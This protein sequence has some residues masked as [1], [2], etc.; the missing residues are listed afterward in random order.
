MALVL[1]YAP[2][3]CSGVTINALEELGLDC[4][5]RK[6]DLSSGEQKTEAYRKINPYGKVPAL[7]SDDKL[8]TENPAILLYLHSLVADSTLLPKTD[9]KY[10]AA[11]YSSDLMWMSSSVHPSVRHV[12]MPMY[13]TLN[14][15]TTDVVEKGRQS[16][17]SYFNIAEK[18]LH[19]QAWWY[20]SK[21]S[22]VDV[23]LHWCYTRA[24]RGGY[25]LSDF[26]AL[27]E[28][29]QR[30]EARP[31]FQRRKAIENR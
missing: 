1:Y 13:Y 7:I 5:Y 3:A 22:I 10:Q 2:G 4:D 24:L 20:G 6:I 29:Q 28:H 16:L 21:W 30:V 8:L 11:L 12:C 14:Q 9:D 23:Y 15:D 26:P 19:N 25:S 18:R 17:T 27:L 31:S